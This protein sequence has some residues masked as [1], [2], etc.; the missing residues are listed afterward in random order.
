MNKAFFAGKGEVMT[1]NAFHPTRPGWNPDWEKRYPNEYGFDPAKARA[2][3][4]EAGYTASNPLNT[5]MFVH[6]LP[7]YARR[8]RVGCHSRL[9]AVHRCEHRIRPRDSGT[10]REQ[11]R[12]F[13]LSNNYEVR[14]TSSGLF[15]AMNSFHWGFGARGG[16]R[17]IQI[18]IAS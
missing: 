4:A 5:T 18:S 1:L 10:I 8:G 13:S 17:K 9:L 7:E 2:L 14:G 15:T 12:T 6:S 3:L 11:T 16:G